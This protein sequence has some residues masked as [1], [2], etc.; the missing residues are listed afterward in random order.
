MPK[1]RWLF[2][3]GNA[4]SLM[5]RRHWNAFFGLAPLC[6]IQ[7]INK[8]VELPMQAGE[9][10][11]LLYDRCEE[12]KRFFRNGD[13]WFRFHKELCDQCCD[14]YVMKRPLEN[15]VFVSKLPGSILAYRQDPVET[16]AKASEGYTGPETWE[17]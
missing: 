17:Q 15:N 1:L 13:Y 11:M 8:T 10:I 6:E 2:W 16:L 5:I 7:A 4:Y 12:S 14:F 3:S 9:S